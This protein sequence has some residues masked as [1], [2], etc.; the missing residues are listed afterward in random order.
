[1]FT[2]HNTHHTLYPSGKSLLGTISLTPQTISARSDEL[3]D[4]GD[5]ADEDDAEPLYED[6]DGE[7]EEFEDEGKDEEGL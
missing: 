2:R 3:S 7:L 6:N 1:M 4:E 5:M